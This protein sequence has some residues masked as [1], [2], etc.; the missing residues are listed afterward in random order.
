MYVNIGTLLASRDW[1]PSSYPYV[2][3][4]TGRKCFR[5][6][7]Q[8][9]YWTK[10]EL[11]ITNQE[12]S[13]TL[14]LVILSMLHSHLIWRAQKI[15]FYYKELRKKRRKQVLDVGYLFLNSLKIMLCKTCRICRG[16]N[17]RHTRHF[18]PPG[19]YIMKVVKNSLK[20]LDMVF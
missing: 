17:V 18:E 1:L 9:K 5:H 10:K 16:S 2:R 13:Y 4:E 8:Q 19:S 14:L 6:Q 20:I 11:T 12:Q 15:T 7:S 3:Q